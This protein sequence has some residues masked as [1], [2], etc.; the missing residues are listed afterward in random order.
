[1]MFSIYW[2]LLSLSDIS[3]DLFPMDFLESKRVLKSRMSYDRHL[4]ALLHI[5]A[6][7]QTK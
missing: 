4:Q 2:A 5:L 6:S 3:I 7:V 1:M